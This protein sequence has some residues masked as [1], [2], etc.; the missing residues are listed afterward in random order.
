LQELLHLGSEQRLRRLF[1]SIYVLN[2][3]ILSNSSNFQDPNRAMIVENVGNQTANQ[4]KALNVRIISGPICI[5][6]FEPTVFRAA[7]I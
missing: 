3:Y 2:P 1:S 5:E 6:Q 7:S 4:K